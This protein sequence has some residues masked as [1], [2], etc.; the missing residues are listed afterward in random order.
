MNTL[1][2]TQTPYPLHAF[3]LIG[4]NAAREVRWHLKAPDALI[5]ISILTAKAIACQGVADVEIPIPDAQLDVQDESTE[6]SENNSPL[7]RVPLS[8]NLISIAESGERKTSIDRVVARP[9]YVNDEILAETY[10]TDLA[11]HEVDL[12]IWQSID[13]GLRRKL[14][15]L[16][17]SGES[18]DAVVAALQ[19]H[20][21]KKPTR[22]RLRRVIR[23]DITKAA[24]AEALHGNGESIAL[25]ADEGDILLR[26][27]ALKHLSWL[28]SAWDGSSLPL[29]RADGRSL[30]AR[31][32]RVTTSLMVQPS[33][34]RAYMERR[35]DEARG[36]GYFSRYLVGWPAST[37]GQRF[38]SG[39]EGAWKHLPVFHARMKELLE[40]YDR[41]VASGM[42]KRDV[43][44]FSDEAKARWVALVN[45]TEQ[46]IQVDGAL[47][48]VKDAASKANEITARVAGILHYFSGQ[49]GDITVDTLERAIAIV[50]WH[51]YE[52]QMVMTS[53][54]E[55][56]QALKDAEALRKYLC[57]MQKERRES[58]QDPYCMERNEV[59][60]CG[61]VRKGRFIAA[62][63]ILTARDIVRVGHLDDKPNAA[64]RRPSGPLYIFFSPRLGYPLAL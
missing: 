5:G 53:E 13:R 48:D 8:L 59:R 25:M 60:H 10:E 12:A 32:P 40:E 30:L 56:P 47:H 57:R 1:H 22:P 26:G 55:V 20:A 58:H 27:E 64:F 29:D 19:D 9:I 46:M 14:T 38:I 16:A 36:I 18:M 54:H 50:G 24:I 37:Q 15:K 63:D 39:H 23:G 6:E 43:V 44:R 51:V 49:P 17:Q 2:S 11:H 33:A 21:T 41:R 28:N 3:H 7:R 31:N 52:F 35:G 34:F 45:H 61:P 42:P 62:L 4:E